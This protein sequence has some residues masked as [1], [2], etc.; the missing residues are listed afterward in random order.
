MTMHRSVPYEACQFRPQQKQRV[1][2]DDC[3]G[4]FYPISITVVHVIIHHLRGPRASKGTLAKYVQVKVPKK[5]IGFYI[6]F[7]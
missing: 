3:L 5:S 1:S 7:R 4:M 2:D 6:K